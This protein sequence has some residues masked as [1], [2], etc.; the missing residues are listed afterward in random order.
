MLTRRSVRR[1]EPRGKEASETLAEAPSLWLWS[2]GSY[3]RRWDPEV[4]LSKDS[5]SS[6]DA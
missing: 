6:A 2:L 5:E 3:S 1:R 4:L